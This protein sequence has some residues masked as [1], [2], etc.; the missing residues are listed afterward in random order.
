[1]KKPQLGLAFSASLMLVQSSIVPVQ[2]ADAGS[3][4]QQLAGASNQQAAVKKPAV[5]KSKAV[6]TTTAKTT[7]A[8]SADGHS[9]LFLSKNNNSSGNTAP[10][11]ALTIH[12]SMTDATSAAEAA[13]S[14]APVPSS[15]LVSM[16]PAPS[17]ST[18][19][20]E[21]PEA[22]VNTSSKQLLAQLAPDQMVA[23]APDQTTLTASPI[24]PVVTG[25][26]DLEEFK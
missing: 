15:D 22:A 3:I 9:M 4:W 25:T 11:A 10:A 17:V 18:T 8:P 12:P 1:M 21:A 24:P 13:K 26:V 19:N 23:Q 20:G 7:K 6:H 5:A 14:G 16:G 2:A